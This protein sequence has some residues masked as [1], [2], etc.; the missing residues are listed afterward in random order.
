M[1]RAS[2]LWVPPT[3]FTMVNDP[4]ESARTAAPL[5]MTRTMAPDKAPALVRTVP[6]TVAVPVRPAAAVSERSVS[7]ATAL[8]PRSTDQSSTA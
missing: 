5:P 8:W 2:T 1:A 7:T 3:A 4:V 6:R